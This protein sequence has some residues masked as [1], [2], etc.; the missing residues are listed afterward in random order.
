MAVSVQSSLD[1]GEIMSPSCRQGG[2]LSLSPGCR[3]TVIWVHALMN[4]VQWW[5][6]GNA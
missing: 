5:K 6:V 1:A 3:I 4:L 2:S